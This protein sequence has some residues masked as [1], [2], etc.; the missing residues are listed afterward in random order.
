MSTIVKYSLAMFTPN[1]HPAKPQIAAARIQLEP[2]MVFF[3]VLLGLAP[4]DLRPLYSHSNPVR[5]NVKE[6]LPTIT[7]IAK[8]KK[9]QEIFT[10]PLRTSKRIF[11]T[12][13]LE[14]H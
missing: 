4:A 8:S 11:D 2:A 10:H 1:M 14:N 3:M 12:H 9:V 6:R 5:G 13:R 7:R